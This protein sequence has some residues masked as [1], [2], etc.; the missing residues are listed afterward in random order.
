MPLSL[1]Q[2][3]KGFASAVVTRPK[4]N[5]K[6][7]TFK[8]PGGPDLEVAIG[9]LSLDFL[10]RYSSADYNILFTKLQAFV[11]SS[12]EHRFERVLLD[13][14]TTFRKFNRDIGFT[15]LPEPFIA[16]LI[17]GTVL[18]LTNLDV[19]YR[20]F[21]KEISKSGGFA[22]PSSPFSSAIPPITPP[23]FLAAVAPGES[24]RVT[25]AD[26]KEIAREFAGLYGYFTAEEV[27]WG[28]ELSRRAPLELV[29]PFLK[30]LVEA[31]KS[32]GHEGEFGPGIVLQETDDGFFH[33]SNVEPVRKQSALDR[34]EQ[35]VTNLENKASDRISSL[36]TATNIYDVWNKLMGEDRGPRNPLGWRGVYGFL[37]N[38]RGSLKRMEM[39]S[40]SQREEAYLEPQE[41]SDVMRTVLEGQQT[42]PYCVHLEFKSEDRLEKTLENFEQAG[43]AGIDPDWV[44][45]LLDRDIGTVEL[46]KITNKSGKASGVLLLTDPVYHGRVNEKRVY[47]ALSGMIDAMGDRLGGLDLSEHFRKSG[48]FKL[49]TSE[50]LELSDKEKQAILRL[51]EQRRFQGQAVRFFEAPSEKFYKRLSGVI[52][53]LRETILAVYDGTKIAEGKT[54][55]Q[56]IAALSLEDEYMNDRVIYSRYTVLIEGEKGQEHDL[57]GVISFNITDVNYKGR[58]AVV[59]RIPESMIRR[60]ARGKSLQ[61]ALTNEIGK[62]EL[63]KLVIE[64]G[65][66]KGLWLALTKGVVIYATTQSKRVIK[67]MSRLSNFSLLHTVKG[68]EM[69]EEQKTILTTISKG[70]ADETGAEL[71][72]YK[73]PIAIR[74]E[75]RDLVIFNKKLD[76]RVD[77][78]LKNIGPRGRLHLMGNLTLWVGIKVTAELFFKRLFHGNK[79]SKE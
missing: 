36:Q 9:I 18:D 63:R 1:G 58:K 17:S 55:K 5:N 61:V 56:L 67:D 72:V 32:G 60:E 27:T 53:W 40:T 21:Q 29:R 79:R 26:T 59:V 10:R 33:L 76:E 37:L 74:E 16:K 57:L 34:I 66:F 78:I 23:S 14:H 13:S 6:C 75:E 69:S 51:G 49:D 35:A 47:D 77:E 52:E 39:L 71:N 43:L 20:S 73:G 54:R 8:V 4:R 38:E 24:A 50:V 41:P 7:L 62:R 48:S 2:Q 44:Q 42:D 30:E 68:K 70:Q 15:K 19:K 25:L 3:I 64:N 45:T 46:W 31:G 65:V 12:P 28:A 11:N 22:P